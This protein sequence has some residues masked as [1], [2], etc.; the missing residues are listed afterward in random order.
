MLMWLSADR[1]VAALLE[2]DVPYTRIIS[3]I[4]DAVRKAANMGRSPNLIELLIKLRYK[5]RTS[6][7]K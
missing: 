1:G 3:A 5:I 6:D 2:K 7:I 4:S